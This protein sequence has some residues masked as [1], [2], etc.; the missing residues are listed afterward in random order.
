MNTTGSYIGRT[1]VSPFVLIAMKQFHTAENIITEG[2]IHSLKVE[3]N[4]PG[5][6]FLVD[7]TDCTFKVLEYKNRK[8]N[9]HYRVEI[10]PRKIQYKKFLTNNWQSDLNPKS[11]VM[12]ISESSMDNVTSENQYQKFFIPIKRELV[13]WEGY[14]FDINLSTGRVTKND[15]MTAWLK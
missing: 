10:T 12:T 4:L 2:K 5:G 7:Y 6:C 15:Q 13:G 8:T 9:G 11:F 3:K 14:N 1:Y